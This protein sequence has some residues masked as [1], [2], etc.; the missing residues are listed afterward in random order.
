MNIETLDLLCK[1]CKE[2]TL[3]LPNCEEKTRLLNMIKTLKSNSDWPDLKVG[4]WLGFI[5]GVLISKGI[6]TVDKERDITRPIFHQYLL[7][8]M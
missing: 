5:E 6:T 1:R 3:K 2:L 4:K 7:L 8:L